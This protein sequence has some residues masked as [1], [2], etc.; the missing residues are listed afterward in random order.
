MPRRSS[1]HSGAS[2]NHD[3]SEMA[4]VSTTMRC[5][6]PQLSS[7][8]SASMT[9]GSEGKPVSVASAPRRISTK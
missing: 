3:V 2:R 7:V 1:S 9:S 6:T 4:S 5:S 8:R